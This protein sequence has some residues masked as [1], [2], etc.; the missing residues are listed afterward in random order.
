[1]KN[2][3]YQ[4]GNKRTALVVTDMFLKINGYQLQTVPLREDDV[5]DHVNQ[6]LADAHVAV[7]TNAITAEQLGE[8]YQL[9]ACKV[10]ELSVGILKYRD[11]SIEE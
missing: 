7:C 1:M 5:Q 9:V 8:L 3:V 10:D 11:E 6:Q 2:H 4:D